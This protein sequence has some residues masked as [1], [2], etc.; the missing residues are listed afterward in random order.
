[1]PLRRLVLIGVIGIVVIGFRTEQVSANG[2]GVN[3]LDQDQGHCV[4][5]TIR[6]V[7]S[8]IESTE[9]TIAEGSFALMRV[10]VES[11]IFTNTTGLFQI[12]YGKTHDQTLSDCGLSS[13]D[14]RTFW[15]YKKKGTPNVTSSYHC[16]WMGKITNVIK[17]YSLQR[18]PSSVT[19]NNVTWGAFL[20]G[21]LRKSQNVNFDTVEALYAGGEVALVGAHHDALGWYGGTGSTT[22]FQRTNI[23]CCGGWLTI[24]QADKINTLNHWSIG[25]A[26]S[27]FLVNH[28]P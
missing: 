12:G 23:P 10:A 6:G 5:C 18:R 17:R 27:P 24:Q 14:T 11:D 25:N 1:V 8:D 7:R 20:D 19:G 3:Y 26:P 15:E 13:G 9:M 22:P 21:D 4:G 2:F 16:D 28:L